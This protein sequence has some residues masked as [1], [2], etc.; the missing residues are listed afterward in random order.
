MA[1]TVEDG[2]GLSNADSYLSVA[3]AD[4]YHTNFGNATWTGTT[5]AKESALR[6]AT[7]YLDSSYVWNGD[8]S[9]LTQALGF[10]RINIE[11]FEGR[12]LDNTVPKNLKDATAELALL[13]LS[14]DLNVTT[15]RSN[16]VTK[17]KV[18]DLEIA[19]SSSAPSGREYNLV[20]TLLS[21]LYSSKIGGSTV[22]LVRV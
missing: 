8:I 14:G 12:V 19:Y 10:P 11:D 15:S 22:K 7:Q 13:S 4:T 17:E 6:K 16:Y 20:N 2:T 5:A 9:S 1:I 18:G 3:A 21:S